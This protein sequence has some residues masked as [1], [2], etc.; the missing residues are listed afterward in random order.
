MGLRRQPHRARRAVAGCRPTMG[1]ALAY[2]GCPREIGLS[3]CLTACSAIRCVCRVCLQRHA[4]A[5]SEARVW[6]TLVF[7]SG[8]TRSRVLI[9]LRPALGRIIVVRAIPLAR[10]RG[11]GIKRAPAHALVER[12]AI[13]A[14]GV[15]D[16]AA[17]WTAADGDVSVSHHDVS[18]SIIKW[19]PARRGFPRLGAIGER[20]KRVVAPA[21]RE[22]DGPREDRSEREESTANVR[23]SLHHLAS[24]VRA[25]FRFEGA[26]W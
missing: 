3:A 15:G 16:P 1:P 23:A 14:K 13:I 7:V 12:Q 17:A 22:G 19:I 26:R 24:R 9:K 2:L 20:L 10:A 5:R 4:S 18:W 25:H 8:K 11:P 21:R 6:E